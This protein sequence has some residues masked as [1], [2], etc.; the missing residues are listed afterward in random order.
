MSDSPAQMGVI[1][2]KT[3]HYDNLSSG[4]TSK[5]AKD[6]NSFMFNLK[7]TPFSQM[8]V[9]QICCG[10]QHASALTEAS[11]VYTWGRGT[12]GRLGHG[13]TAMV[14]QPRLIE[15][16]TNV[17]IVKIACGF[18]YSACVSADGE[19]YTWGAGEKW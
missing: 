4:R 16:L 11:Q 7:Y 9:K 3:H 14:K 10:G 5:G 6:Y 8:Q 2:L 12:F 19:L 17:R 13:N 1:V 18:A 15:S